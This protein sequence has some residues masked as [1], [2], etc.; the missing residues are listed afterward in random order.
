MPIVIR[1]GDDDVDDVVDD[2][3]QVEDAGAGVKYE[4]EQSSDG[5]VVTGKYNVLLPGSRKR[6]R[7]MRYLP[8]HHPSLGAQL[9]LTHQIGENE[10]LGR[11]DFSDF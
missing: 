7:S 8:I 3:I 10:N 1:Y 5:G 11:L 9:I 2:V 4:A 6:D